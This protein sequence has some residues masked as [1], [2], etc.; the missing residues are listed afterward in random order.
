MKKMGER[1]NRKL[2]ITALAIALVSTTVAYAAL[3]TSLNISGSI[4]RRG[5][6]WGQRFSN[7]RCTTEGSSNSVVNVTSSNG[8]NLSF[9]GDF[10]NVGDT[11]SCTFNLENTGSLPANLVYGSEFRMESGEVGTDGRYSNILTGQYPNI[12]EIDD[13]HTKCWLTYGGEPFS[14]VAA[15]SLYSNSSMPYSSLDAFEV[16]SNLGIKCQ[17]YQLED[18]DP[19]M[20]ENT[21]TRVVLDLFYV[22]K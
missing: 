11:I 1:K 9:S 7:L 15:T 10:G 4:S 20:S 8:T 16:V 6:S 3:Q 18:M 5:G 22:Q 2:I 17:Y 12:T 19:T 14:S 21:V 13:G